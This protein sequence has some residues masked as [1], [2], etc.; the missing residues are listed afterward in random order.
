[1]N[2]IYMIK[3][4][5]FLASIILPGITFAQ[6]LQGDPKAW[7]KSDFLGFD[8]IGDCTAQTGDISSVFARVSDE[9]LLLR[10]TFDNM[11]TRKHNQVETDNFSGKDISLDLRLIHQP[12][13]KHLFHDQLDLAVKESHSDAYPALRTLQSNLFE[14]A[15][16]L[17]MKADRHEIE[18]SISVVLDGKVVDYFLSD[19]RTSDAEG[20]AAF[21]HHGNQGITYTEVFYG[22]PGGQ[23]GLEGSGFDEVLQVHEAT[24]VP[25]NFHMSG[26]LMPAAS[27][28]NPEFNDWLTTLA[29]EGLIEMM[30]SALGQHIMP[31]VHNNMNDWSVDIEC[32]MV[33][34]KYNYQP[35]TAWVPER[36]WLAPGNY[37]DAGVIDWLGDNWAQH[38][39]WGVVLDDSPHLNG[40]DNRKIHW[41]NN[42]SG[43][44]LRVI[45]INNSFVGNMHY[46]AGGAK[47]QIAGMGPYNI[48]VYGTDWEVAAEMNEHDG[49]FFLDNYES[50]LWWCHDNY[51]GVNVWKTVDAMQ[52]SNFNGTGAEITP[53]TY[54][55]LGGPDGYGGSNNS[56]Y[57]Q[58]A[59]TE[60]HS[61]FHEPKWTYGYIW[62]DAHNNLLGAPDNTLSQLGWYILMINLH[63]TGWHDGGTVAGWEHRYSSHIKN[64]NVYA[65]ASRWTDGQYQ[66][67]NAAYYDDIDHDGVD[68]V[69]MHNQDIFAVF[70]SIGGKINWLFYKDGFG[71][72]H[73]VVGSDMAYW[74]ETDGDYNDG[75]NNH[76]AA[77]S[78]VYPYQQDAVYDINLLQTSGDTVK[79]EFSQWGV[80]KT[81]SLV[82]GNNFLDVMYDFFESEGYIKS[83]WSP[84]LLDLIWSGK[85]NVQR[86]WGDY[87]SYCGQRNAASGATVALVLGNGGGQ[88]NTQ[89]EGTLVLGDE[90]K[91][92]DQFFTRLYAGYTSEPTGT[93]VPELNALA[94]ENMDIIPPTLNPT[95]F[96]VD[97]NTIELTFSEAL[98][99]YSAQDEDNYTLSGFS[100]NYTLINAIRQNDWRKVRLTIQEYWEP[101]DSGEITVT[102]VVDL[103]GN[104][105]QANNTASL[106]IPSGT[107]PHTIAIDGTNDF[108]AETELMASD[109]YNLYITWD[110]DKLYIGF[111]SL[112]LNSGGDLFVNIDTDQVN[113]SGGSSGSWGRVSYAS[114]FEADYQVAIEGGG[115]SIQLNHFANGQWHYPANNNC[116]SYEGW[117]QNGL[118]EISIPWA[119]MGNPDGVALSVHISEEDTQVITAAYP[120]E[121]PTGNHP[122]LTHVYALFLPHI[123]SEMPVA[124][125]EPNTAI[126]LPNLPPEITDYQPAELNLAAEPGETINFSVTANDPENGALSFSWFLDDQLVSETD[127]YVFTAEGQ[128]RT[129]HEVKA[130]VSDMVPGNEADSVMWQVEVVPSGELSA[131]FS[132]T[133]TTICAGGNVQ[134]TDESTGGVATWEW[135]FESGTPATSSEPNPE[136]TYNQAGNFDVSLTVTDGRE[137]STLTLTDYITVNDEPSANAG[138]DQESCEDETIALTGVANNYS[139]LLWSSAGDGIFANPANPVTTYTPGPQD[140]GAGFA[141]IT[142]TAY[143]LTPCPVAA[144]DAMML[145]ILTSP[146]IT[147]QPQNQ[148][149]PEGAQAIFAIAAEGSQPLNY[150]WFGP[151]GEID[152]DNNPQLVIENAGPDDAGEYYCVVENSCGSE[153]SNIATLTIESLLTQTIEIPNGWSGISTWLNPQNPMVA[154]IFDDIVQN[155]NLV[156]LQNYSDMFWPGQNINTIDVNGGWDFQSGYQIK[157][158]G[159]QQITMAGNSPGSKTLNFQNPGWYLIPVLN[160]CGVAPEELFAGIIDDVVIIKEVAGVRLFWPGVFQNLFMLQPGKSYTASFADAV[161]F[162]YP[163][164]AKQQVLNHFK[165]GEYNI[166]LKD[167]KPSGA[168]HIL[169]FSAEATRELNQGDQIELR[170]A[171]GFRFAGITINKPG[172][173]LALPVF[174]NDRTVEGKTGFDEG[175]TLKLIIKRNGQTINAHPDFN[176]RYQENILKTNGMSLVKSLNFNPADFEGED[177]VS[178]SFYPNPSKNILYFEGISASSTLRIYT[179]HGR[180]VYDNQLNNNQLDVATYQPGIYYVYI[181]QDDKSIVK[182]FVKQ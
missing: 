95:A 38:G 137:S 165:S 59:A 160:S 152:G 93:T 136:V 118:T 162:T 132:S 100:G 70:E 31:F 129:I 109:D 116:E 106:L 131:N 42:G 113:N 97:N 51:P 45:P 92:Y 24:G 66:A 139:T 178:L 99:F 107:T 180:L 74:A 3:I 19:G 49:T 20:N 69:V 78:D 29:G 11:V 50:V 122:T 35:R 148:A 112:D 77:L 170:S 142:L 55:L 176:N 10:V 146:A 128:V 111:E 22:S 76:V 169:A 67:T 103:N 134:F 46:D 166:Y 105:I 54:G 33:N 115:G 84:G 153:T 17:G 141:D 82:E 181:Y 130:R 182:K 175:E 40:Y 127:T 63:E 133:A 79:A 143:P 81:I 71:N 177:V 2:K 138:P 121:N 41:M 119:S 164:C 149:V 32:D 26:T 62:D 27:W 104:M 85:S 58:W 34:F 18:F 23:S 65:H 145:N 179:S 151:E 47:N 91:G 68:E 21:V 39:V 36:V 90:I 43:I 172:S 117:A 161:S 1:M 154:D 6:Q 83:G 173:P 72:T 114:Q 110:N 87:G 108:D 171:S 125:M 48:C 88:H 86:M 13:R 61:D 98:E 30:T 123:T 159:D 16:P 155:N 126:I 158:N 8:E 5:L 57:T 124:G 80:K 140:I 12:T 150:T 44:S 101:G 144:S 167:M 15:I 163:D 60:S 96:Q 89:F 64:A 37:P 102:G 73:S 168:S 7:E 25:G 135:A 53:G 52:N 56:W 75:S 14:A 147:S 9:T 94:Q 4:M 174:A 157:V 156:V 28:H 120:P